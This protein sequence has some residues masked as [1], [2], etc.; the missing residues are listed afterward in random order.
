[1]KCLRRVIN[2]ARLTG[3]WQ[4][5]GAR[6]DFIGK[7]LTQCATNAM[8]EA[9][10]DLVETMQGHII[11]QDLDWTPLAPST[12]AKK[13]SS[14]IY[15]DTGDLLHNGI[16]VRALRSN[17]KGSSFFVGANPWVK[18]RSSGLKMSDLLTYL[19]YGTGNIPPR[20]LVRPSYEE[21]KS[22]FPK[23]FAKYMEVELGKGGL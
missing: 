6:I 10:E 12:V 18:H 4:T 14:I 5:A 20:P 9:G 21:F 15:I 16:K 17:K 8:K 19:E 7:K 1:M 23:K 13:G 3:Q 2:M 11:K 22:D